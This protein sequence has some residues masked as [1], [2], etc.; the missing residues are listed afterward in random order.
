MKESTV[1]NKILLGLNKAMRLFRNHVGVLKDEKGRFHRFGLCKGSAD[2]IG[3]TTIEITKDMIGKKLP[4]FTSIEVKTNKGRVRE[5][6]KQWLNAMNNIN[7][8]AGVARGSSDVEGILQD[9]IR[10]LKT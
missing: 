9:Y 10:N 3:Y 5:E 7:A 6:Q 2:L 4:V 1:T 8:V